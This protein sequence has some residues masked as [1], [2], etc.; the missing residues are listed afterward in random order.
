ME[1]PPIIGG[2]VPPLTMDL[3]DG[4]YLDPLD[5]GRSWNAR[6]VTA[7]RRIRDGHERQRESDARAMG[8][9]ERRDGERGLP[10]PPSRWARGG[11]ELRDT[12]QDFAAIIAPG[13]RRP[14]RGRKHVPLDCRALLGEK[15]KRV[16]RS[17]D[18]GEC[19]ARKGPAFDGRIGNKNA[20]DLFDDVRNHGGGIHDVFREFRSPLDDDDAINAVDFPRRDITDPEALDSRRVAGLSPAAPKTRF[21]RTLWVSTRGSKISGRCDKGDDSP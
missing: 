17:G 2:L 9:H 21:R 4:L 14:F 13:S 18:V 19:V 11:G 8:V 10:D 15:A 3:V 20:N 1:G 6:R 7:E 5:E 16:V 12:R